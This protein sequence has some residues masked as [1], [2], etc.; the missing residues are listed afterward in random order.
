MFIILQREGGKPITVRNV[1]RPFYFYILPLINVVYN[2]I[3][4]NTVL[5]SSKGVEKLMVVRYKAPT[6]IPR[7]IEICH[8][9]PFEAKD[10]ESHALSETLTGFVVLSTDHIDVFVAGVVLA[11]ETKSGFIVTG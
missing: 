7:C 6:S 1:V 10:F 9:F 4:F 8:L 11:F 3:T 5:F 2:I